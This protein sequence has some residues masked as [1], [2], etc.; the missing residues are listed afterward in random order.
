MT[1][2]RV[3]ANSDLTEGKGHEITVAYFSNLD[4]AVTEAKDSRHGVMGHGTTGKVYEIVVLDAP[5]TELQRGHDPAQVQIWGYRK[6][7][8]GDWG[9]GFLDNRDAPV[10]DPEYQEYVRLK[11]KFDR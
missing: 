4:R 6:D 10:H 3:T 1:V 7:L 11:Q 2:Y 8:T 5:L 9:Y